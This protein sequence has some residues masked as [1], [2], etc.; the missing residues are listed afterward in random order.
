MPLKTSSSKAAIKQNIKTLKREGKPH[1]QAV[2]IALDVAERSKKMNAGGEIRSMEAKTYPK[3]F[4]PIVMKKQR[5]L[6]TL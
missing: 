4:S 6:G 1:K 3:K 2:A 5:F